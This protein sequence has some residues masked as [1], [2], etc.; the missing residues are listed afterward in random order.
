VVERPFG[1]LGRF[2]LGVLRIAHL[3]GRRQVDPQLEAV[4]VSLPR[5]RHFRVDHAARR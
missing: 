4:N 2:G 1:Q 5:Q 3:V